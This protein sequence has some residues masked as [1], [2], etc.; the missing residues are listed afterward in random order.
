[1]KSMTIWGEDENDNTHINEIISGIKNAFCSPS[2]W[3]GAVPDEPDTTPG[4]QM[5]LKDPSGRN[6]VIIEITEI[7]NLTF[8]EAD[9]SVAKA[10]LDCDLQDFRDAHR[11]YWEEELAE[12]GILMNDDLPIVIEYFKIINFPKS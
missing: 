12:D 4:D 3:Y 8:G 7:K 6:R 5:M 1:M 10:V 11:F 9:E 2:A